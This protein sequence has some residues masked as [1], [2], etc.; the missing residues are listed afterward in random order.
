MHLPRCMAIDTSMLQQ[1][2]NKLNVSTL[3]LSDLEPL[4]D[5][6]DIPEL[7]LVPLVNVES[8]DASSTDVLE[9]CI[10][11]IQ[12][13]LKKLQDVKQWRVGNDPI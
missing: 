3:T 5:T 2:D 1:E 7:V 9:D 6:N 11:L 8:R 12:I 13:M 10:S 4:T